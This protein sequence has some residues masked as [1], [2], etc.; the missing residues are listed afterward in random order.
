MG[1]QFIFN[2]CELHLL[3]IGKNCLRKGNVVTK[4]LTF[5]EALKV[6]NTPQQHLHA[7]FVHFILHPK[8]FCMKFHQ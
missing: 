7:N 4:L 3:Q 8:L 5:V 2:I 1:D 6:V